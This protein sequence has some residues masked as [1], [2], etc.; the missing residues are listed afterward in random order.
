MNSALS[1]RL[2]SFRKPPVA[3]LPPDHFV[4]VQ[5][6]GLDF[7]GIFDSPDFEFDSALDSSFGKLMVQTTALLLGGDACGRYG[8]T[9]LTQLSLLI[10][11]EAAQQRFDD[12][13]DLQNYLVG[14]ASARMSLLLRAEALFVCRLY[15]F[16]SRELVLAYFT[17]RQQEAY[18]SALD[19]YCSHVLLQ[20]ETNTAASVSTLLRDLGPREKV[21]IL[22]QNALDYGTVPAWQRYGVGVHLDGE[23][24]RVVTDLPRDEHYR[25]FVEQRL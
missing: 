4:V 7:D 19:G 21:E 5:L 11:H 13:T 9:E 15:A 6:E 12:A 16:P 1:E 25:A 2:K 10:D 17:W 20:D 23:Q 22:K 24:I 14:L 3:G 8:Y 18:L